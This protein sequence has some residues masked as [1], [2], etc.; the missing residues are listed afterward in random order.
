MHLLGPQSMVASNNQ[1]ARRHGEVLATLI[2]I[3]H[4]CCFPGSGHTR[5]HNHLGLNQ[6]PREQ[7]DG[8]QTL[9]RAPCSARP[10][11]PCVQLWPEQ[12]VQGKVTAHWRSEGRGWGAHRAAQPTQQGSATSHPVS[13]GPRVTQCAGSDFC[14]NVGRCRPQVHASACPLNASAGLPP[15][16]ASCLSCWLP[17]P[18]SSL[19]LRCGL[20]CFRIGT[21]LLALGLPLPW[22]RGPLGAPC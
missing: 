12:G 6:W 3:T 19:V 22:L 16:L 13:G 7:P 20:H 10:A 9:H 11:T 5:S 2:V 15:P 21:E 18:A 8:S 17:A 4:L 1:Q 14:L